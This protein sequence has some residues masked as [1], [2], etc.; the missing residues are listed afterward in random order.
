MRKKP[1]WVAAEPAARMVIRST[2]IKKGKECGK[3]EEKKGRPKKHC[4]ANM[5]GVFEATG[6]GFIISKKI[7]LQV[8]LDR[9]MFPIKTSFL[10]HYLCH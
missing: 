1:C 8:G 3:L 5:A 9:P 10:L 4:N 2:K 7:F 6:I